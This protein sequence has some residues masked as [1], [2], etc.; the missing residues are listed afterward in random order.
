MNVG[1]VFLLS[2]G[3]T[4]LVTRKKRKQG[5]I[6][7]LRFFFYCFA[8]GK[9][10]SAITMHIRNH[11]MIHTSTYS[12]STALILHYLLSCYSHCF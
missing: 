8:D 11:M 9:I 3:E 2:P 12:P 10:G 4:N 7:A 5:T 6:L 1:L